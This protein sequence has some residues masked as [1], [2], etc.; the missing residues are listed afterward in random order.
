MT[1]AYY[2]SIILYY[3][4]SLPYLFYRES[5]RQPSGN[6]FIGISPSFQTGQLSRKYRYQKQHLRHKS[7][8]SWSQSNI[9]RSCLYFNI[10][11][12]FLRLQHFYFAS[13]CRKVEMQTVLA[14]LL[15]SSSVS[16][17]LR[18]KYEIFK[19]QRYITFS[20]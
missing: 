3:S 17:V 20:Q 16:Y 5:H 12:I 2:I 8:T 9:Y 15:H 10:I 18:D 19:V 6:G 7:P 11:L 1:T 14:Y 13:R 4:F